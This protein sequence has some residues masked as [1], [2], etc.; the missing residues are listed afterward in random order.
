[1][2]TKHRLVFFGNE[3][4]C[5]GLDTTSVATLK[6]L[7]EAG[8]RIEL[9]VASHHAARSRRQRPLEVEAVAKAHG[10]PV[11]VTT[12]AAE[13]KQ[14]L[15]KLRPT[16]GV[17]VAYGKI[18][19][20]AIID[21]FERGII[22]LHPSLLPRFRGPTPIEQAILD[23]V[24]KTGVSLMRLAAAMDAGPV[25]AQHEVALSGRETKAQLAEELLGAG[26]KLMIK[27]LPGILD[28]SL[29]PVPQDH[30][31][32]TYTR[33]ITKADGVIDW[34]MPADRIERQI[35]AYLGWPGSRTT[36]AG[37]DVTITAARV[38]PPRPGLEN[39]K[40]VRP[41][42]KE[43]GT[44]LRTDLKELAVACGQDTLVI[45]RLKPAGKAEMTGQAFLAGRPL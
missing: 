16:A 2:S 45:E 23:G 20:P 14:R 18:V 11:L 8:Y 34:T 39:T 29:Q 7:V 36:L 12:G 44:V 6:A 35:R 25:F 3:R 10:I 27:Y 26:A 13:I 22:N 9:V 40:D 32:A 19:P 4:L 1:M 37:H 17:L 21:L 31:Q 15:V 5:T 41:G 28:G 33:L 38:A 24:T 42:L 43:P 30:A